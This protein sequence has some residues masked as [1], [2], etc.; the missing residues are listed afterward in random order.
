M[1]DW[2][3]C[4]PISWIVQMFGWCNPVLQRLPFLGKPL[5]IETALSLSIE[6]ADALD[7]AHAK[8][9]IHRDIKPGNIF[10]TARELA[11]VLDFGVAKLPAKVPV[12]ADATAA[13]INTEEHLTIP[14]TAL[15]TVAYMS[16][17]QVRGQELDARTDLFSFGVVL[18]EM[19]TGVL[20]FR[21]DTSGL[22]F[23]ATLNRLPAPP[24]RLNPDVPAELERIINKCLEKDRNLRYQRASEMRTDLQR[25]KR[26]TESGKTGAANKAPSVMQKSRRQVMTI[27]IGLAVIIGG[28]T[29]GARR[30]FS[31]PAKR[32][33]S[34]VVL[35]LENLSRDPEQE[36]FTDGMTDALITDLSKIGALRVISRTSAMHYKGTNKT[37]PEIARELNVEG[38]V[39]GSVMRSGNRVRITAQLIQ[40]QTDKHLWAETY[41]RDLGDVLRLQGEVAQAIAQRVRIELTPQQQARLGSAPRV[42]PEAYEAYIKGRSTLRQFTPQGIK[43]AQH[44]FEEAIQKDSDFALAYVGLADCY[45]WLGDFRR[46][47][48]QDAYRQA[49]QTIRKALELDD[50]LAEAHDTLGWLDWRFEWN[51]QAAETELNSA[52]ELNPNYVDGHADRA[53]YLAWSGRRTEA[54][55]EITRLREL[56]AEPSS[57]PELA[58]HYHLRDY[59]SNVERSQRFVGLNPNV[60]VGHYHLGVSYEG[61]GRR[62]E[63]IPE[64]QKAVQLSE[65]DQDPTA[66]LAHAYALIGR[67]ADAEKILGELERQSKSSYVSPYTIATIYAGLGD[68]EKAFEF[69]EKAYQERSSDLPYFLKA[70]LRIDTLRPDPR[71]ADLVR[72]V[73]LPQ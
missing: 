64:Y 45:R 73:G 27:V 70:D 72:R 2:S 11:K 39:E 28:L 3:P 19:V 29:L 22:I 66:A 54:L 44:Y 37:L 71:F 17:E 35:P 56:T 4:L 62:L 21:G 65:G 48:P 58:I 18:Y 30:Y 14:G 5:D 50:T 26:D 41:E 31:A 59:T 52:V 46:L 69:L 32:I 42:N 36:Y 34:I 67:R 8:G 15:G 60:W 23:D 40:A 16:P 10:V 24:M 7:A 68:K 49:K 63:S 57:A 61:S 43:T 12:H 25:L 20:P 6:I 51:W 13:T 33:E 9:I 55:A 38:V 1:K 47:P 53:M